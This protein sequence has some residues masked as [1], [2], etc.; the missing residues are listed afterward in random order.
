MLTY[1]LIDCHEDEDA[2]TL[3]I[4]YGG[5]LI[6]KP[7]IAYYGGRVEYFDYFCGEKGSIVCLR[8]M[9]KQ[10]KCDDRRFNF[11]FKRG[12][13]VRLIKG[14]VELYIVLYDMPIIR[15]IDVF[16]EHVTNEQWDYNVNMDGYISDELLLHERNDTT[17]Q[18]GN[19]V[20]D[21]ICQSHSHHT[22]NLSNVTF[23]DN[24][25]STTRN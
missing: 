8:R 15:E 14:D 13:E 6:L 3:K 9:V 5:V 10:L 16:V 4:Y 18:E 2:Y 19:I 24:M 20:V 23:D 12:E 11:W 21:G 7:A 17:L 1:L 22:E 25:P